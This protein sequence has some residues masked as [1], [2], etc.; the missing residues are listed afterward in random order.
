[1]NR[2]R[3]D[4]DVS[5][6][7]TILGCTLHSSIPPDVKSIVAMKVND[8]KR[9]DNWTVDDHNSEHQLD[10][11][12]LQREIREIRQ[13]VDRP[14]RSILVITHHAPTIQGTSKPSDLR[15]PW[16]CAFSTDLLGDEALSDVQWW[17][18]GHTH[19]TSEFKRGQVRLVS[20]QRGYVF[21]GVNM[22]G[23]NTRP[24]KGDVFPQLAMMM[25]GRNQTDFDVGKVI[26][27]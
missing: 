5:S 11:Q 19:F 4:L 23:Q 24:S 7:I 8:F 10:V 9:I 15:N 17:V 13:Q 2:V 26:T 27:I 18:F 1:M 16:S 12:W 21:N 14:K 25:K 22:Q 3:V 20:N 6:D